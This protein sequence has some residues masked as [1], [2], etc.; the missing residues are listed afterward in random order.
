MAA[1]QNG[2]SQSA[3]KSSRRIMAS[4][5]ILFMHQQ[6]AAGTRV[7]FGVKCRGI[8]AGV[9]GNDS[10]SLMKSNDTTLSHRGGGVL[11]KSDSA[12]FSFSRRDWRQNGR[13]KAPR[14][15]SHR[16]WG[17]KASWPGSLVPLAAAHLVDVADHNA[18]PASGA[19]M[20]GSNR[21]RQVK[22]VVERA[23][24]TGVPSNIGKSASTFMG[25]TRDIGCGCAI[26]MAL[27]LVEQAAFNSWR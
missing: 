6:V 11:I 2:A 3:A 8:G 1:R 22:L 24:A 23:W 7:F 25:K 12:P 20:G 9:G 15:A 27:K 18:R 19:T 16:W 26:D 5:K 4:S 17:R 21:S 10:Q 13:A 14:L